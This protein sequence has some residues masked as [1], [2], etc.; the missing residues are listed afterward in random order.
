M[1]ARVVPGGSSELLRIPVDR[2]RLPVCPG[3][4][5]A[6]AGQRLVSRGDRG[7]RASGGGRPETL[8]G[9]QVRLDAR[10]IG[11]DRLDIAALKAVDVAL[12]AVTVTLHGDRVP[13]KAIYERDGWVC[14]M[15]VCTC[16][17]GRAIDPELASPHKWSAS[18]D[19][20]IPLGEGGPDT[21]DNKRAAHVRCN[22]LA[23]CRRPRQA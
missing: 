4:R 10:Q 17:S 19:H 21:A 13:D 11:L 6:C 5:V 20:A 23:N 3:D 1:R 2:G 8:E 14:Q 22:V 9:A 15:P 12:L 16:P 18:I 7:G